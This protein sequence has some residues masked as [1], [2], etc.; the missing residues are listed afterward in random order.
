[1]KVGFKKIK[2]M[3]NVTLK[4]KKKNEP[5]A[6]KAFLF[7]YKTTTNFYLQPQIL[8]LTTKARDQLPAW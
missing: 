5:E 1:M 7:Y 3:Q 6:M 2:D 4:K 8:S